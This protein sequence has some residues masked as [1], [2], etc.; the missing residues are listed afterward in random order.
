M[1]NSLLKN[2][3]LIDKRLKYF[4]NLGVN[5]IG[6]DNL[7]RRKNVDKYRLIDCLRHILTATDKYV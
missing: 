3:L 4:S 7:K 2:R 6:M 5:G 1:L